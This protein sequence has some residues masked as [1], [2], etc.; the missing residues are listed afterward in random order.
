MLPEAEETVPKLPPGFIVCT[1][2]YVIC[3]LHRPES[4]FLTGILLQLRIELVNLAPNSIL[5]LTIFQHICEGLLGFS[6][7]LPCFFIS[8]TFVVPA[9]TPTN[10]LAA[11]TSDSTAA[12]TR[13]FL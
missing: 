10:S 2:V 7:R 9:T 4:D 12:L 11:G 6:P 13:S 1:E 8:T 5:I 3:G